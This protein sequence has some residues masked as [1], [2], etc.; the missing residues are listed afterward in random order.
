MVFLPKDEAKLAKAKA[1][2]EKAISNEG[3]KVL[4]WRAVPTKNE[5]VGPMAKSTQPGIE[6]CIIDGAGATG[7]DAAT[8]FGAGELQIVPQHIDQQTIR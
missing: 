7:A 3:M 6:Q 1:Q 8:V 5:I 2:L 4:G